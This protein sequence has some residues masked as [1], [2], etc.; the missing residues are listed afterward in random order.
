MKSFSLFFLVAM[1]LF[2]NSLLANG[3][4]IVDGAQGVY[5]RLLESDVKVE[6]N[7]QIAVTTARHTF[8]NFGST[9][10]EFKYA[11]PLNETSNPVKLRWLIDGVW[12]EADVSA[13][14]Q[15]TDIPGTSDETDGI[16]ADLADYLGEFPLFFSPQ[17][18]LQNGT[19]ISVEL[20]YV[21][22]LPY[23]SGRV[24]FFHKNDL[25]RLQNEPIRNQ[26]FE[27]ILESER[28][29]TAINL[30]GLEHEALLTDNRTI[31]R[32][33]VKESIADTDYVLEY[34]LSSEGLGVVDLSTY[35]PDSL[36]NCDN[37]GGGY[38]SLI[39]EPESNVDSEVIKKNFTLIIDRSG[40]MSGNKI[41]Q[42][43]DAASFIVNNLNFGDFFNII[44]FS[45]NIKSL[46]EEPQPYTLDNERLALDYIDEIRASGSTNISGALTRAISDFEVV[47]V[48]K[49]NIIIFF[50]DGMA[51]TGI[52]SSQG[53][54]DAVQDQVTSSETS[55]F[56]FTFGI[57]ENVDRSLL[58]L[59][60]QENDGLVNFV[61]DNDLE[62]DVTE[63]FL[64][65][66]NP[67]L[68]NT[69]I[70]FQ[71]DIIKEVYPY[72]YPNLYKGEQLI[73][74]GRYDNAQ[75]V[76]VHL[77]GNAFNLPVTY[78]F[79]INLADTN[80][81]KRSILPKIWAKQKIDNLTLDFYA[82]T[83]LIEAETIQTEIDE[84]SIC[85][86]VISVEFTSFE[87]DSDDDDGGGGDDDDD[88]GDY[89]AVE[90][91]GIASLIQVS[92]TVFQDF[93]EIQF[94]LLT[95]DAQEVSIELFD[96]K[97]SLVFQ[98]SEQLTGGKFVGTINGLGNLPAGIYICKIRIGDKIHSVKLIKL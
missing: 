40:S 6:V 4:I 32:Y 58:T 43:R 39:I 5:L 42:A 18:T 9:L 83:T 14:T 70:S 67:V 62:E 36:L 25:S 17:D 51:T 33:E 29:I 41:E 71:P 59:L 23:Y 74:S 24:N 28:E 27:F 69:A 50:T 72:P 52:T 90:D 65:V 94:E 75:V 88:D 86:G 7:N 54:R 66:N 8:I 89:A 82:A 46:F 98:K 16:R 10:T 78:D 57:G 44:D 13:N 92:P 85:Y 35:I 2:S 91:E 56:L 47:D 60:A 48:D 31:L 95:I 38:L 80:D 79:E 30:F 22:L 20:T 12:K 19:L 81:V 93:F 96:T 15:D 84:V 76:N 63:F 97:G 73:L 1:L 34:E 26:K 55:I 45:T 77:E 3:I 37:N 21:E 68:I 53:I 11:F 87:D 61:E 49:A 64:S